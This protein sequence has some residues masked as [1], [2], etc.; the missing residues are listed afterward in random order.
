MEIEE[1]DLKTSDQFTNK[2]Y[3]IDLEKNKLIKDFKKQSSDTI[4]SNILLTKNIEYFKLRYKDLPYLQRRTALV[5]E[6]KKTFPEL[7]IKKLSKT[8]TVNGFVSRERFVTALL[9]SLAFILVFL[10]FLVIP[11]FYL[12]L[13]LVLFLIQAIIGLIVCIGILR[14]LDKN[15]L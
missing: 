2:Q 7:D 6:L 13:N 9:A 4:E 14:Y 3:L 8:L 15:S 10:N 1:N 11:F 12:I 5:N